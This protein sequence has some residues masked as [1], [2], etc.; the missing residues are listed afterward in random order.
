MNELQQ[1]DIFFELL[2]LIFEENTGNRLELSKRLRLSPCQI[3]R[4]K[5][6]LQRIFKTEIVYSKKI[7]TY[8]FTNS[9]VE[10]KIIMFLN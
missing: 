10:K 4:Y 2:N 8:K 7:R 5:N 9:E 1:I 3:T 6:K